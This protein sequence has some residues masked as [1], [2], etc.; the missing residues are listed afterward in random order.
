MADADK[1]EAA[2]GDDGPQQQPPPPLAESRRD[3]HPAEPEKPP[4]SSAN[5]VKME[6][7]ES[8]K[9]EKSD[10]KEK[11]TGNKKANR[12]HPY[13]KDKNSGTGEKKGPNRNRVFISNI[14]YDMKWQAIKDLMREKVGE[15]TYVELFKDAEGKSRGC[16]VVEFKD[17]EFVK[18]ALETM[19]KYD[20][21]GRPL[22]IKE[23]PDGENARRALQRTGTSFQGSHASDVG[24][25]LVNLPPSILNNPNIPPEVIS[26]LQAGRLGSTIFV[27]NLDFKVGWKKLKEVFSIAGT[28]KRAD[29]KEDK[30]GKSRGMGTVTFEQ[31]IEAVQ[32]I[33]MFNGQFL[34]DRPM[35]VK[36]DDKSVPHE[37]YRSH[38][39]KTSQLPRGLGGIGMGLGPGGQ[40]ISASQLNISGV[41]GNLGPSGVGF[42]GLEAM[43]SMA[44]FGGVGRMG[45]LYRGAVTSSMERDFGRGDIGIN[46]GFGDSFGRLG[47]SMGGMSSVTGGMGMGLDRM[48]SSFDRMGPG[49][50]AILERSIDVDRGFLSGPMGS[51]MR[52]RLG[53][54]GNQIFV[55]N[56][57]FDLTW[58]KL[59]E[60]FSQCGH[61]MFAEIKMEN[62]KSKGCGTVRF[63]S[64]ESAEKA[65][66]IMNGIKISGREIDVRLDRNA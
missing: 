30:D 33:S 54:K 62:G 28:V 40:P 5:G 7:D 47:G 16:G 56:L 27:A 22:N 29:I 19:N 3:P 14:P 18:K 41:M 36:M 4:R 2:T 13:S 48:S 10:L 52:D 34:F 57:P 44:G 25:G 58:Q 1:P 15:V 39:S 59:K 50:G 42:G 23:D 20:L 35:H 55:R 53:S 66:R 12:F 64:P 8:V 51:G 26:N 11:S 60:K 61:V 24:S 17:E 31:A 21:S 9:E 65:C 38:D 63:E 45:E 37:D 32:A 43:N 49:I 46:R 6:N